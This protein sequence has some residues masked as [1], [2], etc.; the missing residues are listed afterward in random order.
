MRRDDEQGAAGA[1]KRRTEL[2]DK[3]RNGEIRVLIGSTFKLG[4]GVNVQ[5]KLIAVHHLDVPWRPADMTQRESRILRQGNQNPKIEIYRYITEGSFDAYSWQL[6]ETKQR[7][8]TELL[9]GSYTERDSSDIEDTVLDFAEVKALAVGN[10]LVKKRVETAN[11]LSRYLTLQRKLVE[12]RLRLKA[13]LRE[14]PA[15]ITHQKRLIENAEKDKAFYSLPVPITT[16]EKNAVAAD[17]KALQEMIFAAVKD[18]ELRTS[19]SML[20]EY[21]GFQIILPANMKK[22]KPFVRLQRTGRYYVELGDTEL[23]VLPRIDNF[24]DG[25][26]SHI[27]SLRD[28]LIKMS[29]PETHIRAELS[30]P[31]NY[32]DKINDLKNQIERI[33]KKLGADKK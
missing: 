16:A 4:I 19:E 26:G 5:D 17:R 30:S 28:R 15:S 7:F 27:G 31:E 11:E 6:L 18:N 20:T 29:E 25:M 8:I 3:M 14:L 12:A 33:D 2:F 10:P 1:E 13:E 32:T 23:G 9:S 24:L 22:E 21:R